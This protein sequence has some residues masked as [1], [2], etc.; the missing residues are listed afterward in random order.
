MSAPQHARWAVH[1][2]SAAAA[3]AR[4][5]GSRAACARLACSAEIMAGPTTANLR[6][7]P[8]RH[9][10]STRRSLNASTRDCARAAKPKPKP[11]PEDQEPHTTPD[12]KKQTVSELLETRKTPLIGLGLAAAVLGG[13]V[14]MLALSMTGGGDGDGDGDGCCAAPSGRPLELRQGRISAVMFDKDLNRPES[15]MG[16]TGLR[17]LMGG[18]ARGHVLEVAVGTGRNVKYIDWDEIRASAPPVPQ[19]DGAGEVRHVQV[20]TEAELQRDRVRR[21]LERGEKGM[22]LPGDEA[23]E[24]VSYT[25]MD[26][27]MDVLEVAWG[28]LKSEV[29]ELIPRRRRVLKE[30][31]GS[32]QRK[33]Q[34]QQTGQV[35]TP[36]QSPAPKAPAPAASDADETLAANIGQGRIRLFKSDAQLHLPSPPAVVSHDSSKVLPA[37]QYYDTILQNFGLCSVSNPQALLANMAAVLRPGSGRIYLLEHGRGSYG[38]L[39]ALLDR[40]APSHFARYGCWWNRD[41]EDMVRRA[42]G[43]VP[44]LEIVRVERPLW[45]QGGTMLWIELRVNPD[46][47]KTSA[48]GT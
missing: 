3:T 8:A 10:P 45:L 42:E 17:Q 2:A 13:Y 12:E 6:W 9:A 30:E 33:Q 46:R 15:L 43:E 31:A 34:Q 5:S 20:K 41:I 11:N 48:P 38:W 37:P 16:V 35:T 36:V 40:F 27:S 7:Q 39:N 28:K 26:I 44:G 18:L 23:P 14:V 25:G 47:A 32:E 4:G 24:V 1:A 21:R 22:L 29:P 19:P